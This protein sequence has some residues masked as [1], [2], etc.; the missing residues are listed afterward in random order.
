MMPRRR[1]SALPVLG[2]LA[3]AGALAW[4]ASKRASPATGSS[5]STASGPGWSKK[6]SSV[7][8]SD[9][10]AAWLDQLGVLIQAAGLPDAVVTS[11]IRTASEQAAVMLKN[12][13]TNG[14]NNG[15]WEYLY[16]LYAADDLIDELTEVEPTQDAWETV[17]ADAAE[18]GR[19]LSSHQQAN[20]VDLRTTSGGHYTDAQI[21]TLIGLV[22]QAGGKPLLES[23]HLH[24]KIDQGVYTS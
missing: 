14:G 17:I 1:Q 10:M 23:D 22:E 9:E 12:W 24:V 8:L 5:S 6:S 18:Q 2:G 20:A 3:L 13:T 16:G 15:G 21:E 7:V 19:L 4:Q 11:G